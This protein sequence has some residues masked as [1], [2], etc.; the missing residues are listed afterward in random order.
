MRIASEI[1]KYINEEYPKGTMVCL[2]SAKGKEGNMR[3]SGLSAGRYI[4]I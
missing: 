3:C 1:M 2:M 4:G